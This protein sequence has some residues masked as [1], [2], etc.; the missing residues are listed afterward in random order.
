MNKLLFLLF[1]S[2][3]TIISFSQDIHFSQQGYS[4]LT[5]NP[6]LTGANYDLTANVNYRNQWS[7]VATPFQTIAASVDTRLNARK[8]RRKKAHIAMGLNFFNDVSGESKI[9]TNNVNLHL[10]SHIIM[11]GGH[12]FGA[13][14]YAGWGQ[15]SINPNAGQWGSQYNG[16]YY[17]P[18]IVSGETFNNAAF[19]LFDTGAGLVY[20]YNSGESR[21]AENDTK[22]LNIG[23]AA[24]HLNRP[25]YSF[26]Q[27]DYEKLYMRFSGF[28]NGS[29]GIRNTRFIVE[30]GVYY[31]Q[32]GNA[33][34]VMVGTYGRYILKQESRITSFILRTTVAVGLF[35][36]NQDALV[37]KAHFEWNG[38][39]VGVAYDFNLFNSLVALSKS[40]GGLEISLRWVIPDLYFKSGRI[41]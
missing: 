34:E 10:A 37:A 20:T 41:N 28:V 23:F 27:R 39:G 15:R 16:E 38:L 21:I 12:T 18:L 26:I 5:L 1:F 36:R 25:S 33:R 11:G 31:H 13:G 8:K 40:R 32:Q 24:F 19:S 17:D 3:L 9:T 6:G 2:F 29:F 30:P 7:S 4:P 35:Y 14:I 22:F